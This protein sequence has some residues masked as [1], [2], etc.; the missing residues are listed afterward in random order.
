VNCDAAH[1]S[2]E[3][4]TEIP[5]GESALCRFGLIPAMRKKSQSHCI[6]SKTNAAQK[7]IA[8]VEL[9]LLLM[10][11]VRRVAKLLPPLQIADELGNTCKLVL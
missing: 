9:F 6:E 5:I 1:L 4:Q 7:C 8:I 11:L 3:R 2:T 10:L